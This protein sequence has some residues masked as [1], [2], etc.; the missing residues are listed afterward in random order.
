MREQRRQ[1]ARAS[2]RANRGGWVWAG[3]DVECRTV[4]WI[5]CQSIHDRARRAAASLVVS[6]ACKSGVSTGKGSPSGMSQKRHSVHSSIQKSHPC[7]FLE[8]GFTTTAKV[9]G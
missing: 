3:G 1:A 7:V 6:A 9:D 2:S 8:S 4:L 5:C